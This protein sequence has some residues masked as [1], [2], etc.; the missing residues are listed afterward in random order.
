MW[1]YEQHSGRMYDASGKCVATGYAG[2][3]V[4]KNKP[5]DQAIQG[6]GPLPR[7][8]YAITAPRNSSNTGPYSM[9]LHPDA[10]NEM[11][12][13]SAFLIHGDSVSA[14]GTASSGCIIMPRPVREAIWNSGDHEIEVVA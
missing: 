1:K 11:F 4:H 12:G 3:G 7:G 5:D 2:K 6:Q 13:R 14:P 9:D 8:K 10:S